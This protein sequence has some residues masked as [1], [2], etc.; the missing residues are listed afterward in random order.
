MRILHAMECTIGGTRRHLVDLALGQ[1]ALG[2]AVHVVAAALRDPGMAGDLERLMAAGVEVSRL[3]M[4]RSIAPAKDWAHGR[5]LAGI[6]KGWQPEIVH[7]HSSKAGVLA[8]RASLRTGVGQRVHTPH[9]MAFL[10]A[11]LFSPVKRALFRRIEAGLAQKTARIV[12]VSPSEAHTLVSSGVV[13]KGQVRVVCNGIDAAPFETAQPLDL[14]EF[15]LDPERPTLALV[16]LVYAAKG[17]DLCMEALDDSELEDWQLL[18]VGPGEIAG[19]Q[20]LAARIG[21]A[22]RVVF[23]GPRDDVPRILNSVDGLVLPSRWEGMPYVVLEAMAAG[24]PVVSHPVDGARDA[25]VDGG[26]RHF[27]RGHRRGGP[28]GWAFAVGG[29]GG[30]RAPGHG[31][32][33]ARA[34]AGQL[35]R[36]GHGS[37]HPRRVR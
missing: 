34:S 2:H 17:Q 20:E 19:G 33:G 5:A 35:L 26:D 18:C 14:R 25:V 6:L 27:V 16:G 32:K 9:T 11:D 30:G 21:I 31:A 29:H 23:A 15:G 36:R 1:K 22:D 7:S 10:F 8:R 37:G 4:V 3:D 13:A 28:A 12:A 24:L